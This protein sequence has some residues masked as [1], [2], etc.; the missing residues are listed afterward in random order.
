M[1]RAE[2]RGRGEEGPRDSRDAGVPDCAQQ[3]LLAFALRMP[4]TDQ[5]EAGKTGFPLVALA[6]WL[7]KDQ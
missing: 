5:R 7:C 1:S 3:D 4:Q 6:H 2:R